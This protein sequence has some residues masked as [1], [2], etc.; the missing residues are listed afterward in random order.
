MSD[1]LESQLDSYAKAL[2]E[3]IRPVS[4]DEVVRDAARV[5]LHTTWAPLRRRPLLAVLTVAALV[6]ATV[7]TLAVVV[8]SNS[9]KVSPAGSGPVVKV[10]F[11][12]ASMTTYDG[13]K[14]QGSVISISCAPGGQSC[15]AVGEWTRTP[16]HKG[17]TS[18]ASQASCIAPL[19]LRYAGETW[20]PVAPPT[21]AGGSVIS[22]ACPSARSCDAVVLGSSGPEFTSLLEHFNGSTWSLIPL[23]SDLS[24]REL[25]H[26]TCPAVSDCYFGGLDV[27]AAGGTTSSGWISQRLDGHWLAVVNE[28]NIETSDISCES[29][30]SCWA[31]G[32][33][34]EPHDRSTVVALQ[35]TDGHWRMAAT[36][37]PQ[38][39]Y[40]SFIG[41][42][43]ANPSFC[44]AVGDSLGGHT[45]VDGNVVEVLKDGQWTLAHGPSIASD[46]LGVFAVA[47][48]THWG[49]IA[50]GGADENETSGPPEI[51]A[52]GTDGSWQP[53]GDALGSFGAFESLSCVLP[54]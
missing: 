6:V 44:V 37:T 10:A 2:G 27:A 54:T 9:N 16:P 23:P 30:T 45:L 8:S 48:G 46:R 52:V 28:P 15:M 42:A 21:S 19:V 12:M 40:V 53:L 14:G 4:L 11:S 26:V 3:Q 13:F 5:Q 43:C 39:S 24:H 36:A 41:I 35:L 32:S 7:G 20:R 51:L 47:C 22:V 17:L 31:V 34:V 38:G 18:C 29:P 33:R 49:C 50:V 1:A 25:T